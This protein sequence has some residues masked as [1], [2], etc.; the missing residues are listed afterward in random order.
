MRVLAALFQPVEA[1][2]AQGGRTVSYEELGA[3]WLALG[4]RKRAERHDDGHGR[5]VETCEAETRRDARLTAGRMLRFGGGDWRIV[6]VDDG[7]GNGRATLSLE[8]MR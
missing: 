3:A 4:P 1:E 5:A 2:T 6:A 7:G 8:R